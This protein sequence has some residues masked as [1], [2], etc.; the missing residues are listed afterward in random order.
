MSLG[1]AVERSLAS[2]TTSGGSSDGSAVASPRSLSPGGRSTLSPSRPRRGRARTRDLLAQV[3][4]RV[5]GLHCDG[6]GGGGSS[7]S[8]SPRDGPEEQE[9]GEE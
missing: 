9:H 1:A 6:G 8:P 2:G 7:G 3:S 4:T 5:A